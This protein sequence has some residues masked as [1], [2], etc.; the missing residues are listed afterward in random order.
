V[1][2]PVP[3]GGLADETSSVFFAGKVPPDDCDRWRQGACI[4]GLVYTRDDSRA[5]ASEQQRRRPPDTAAGSGDDGHLAG[6]SQVRHSI[7][8]ARQVNPAARPAAGHS[9]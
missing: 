9:I 3:A 1:E 4:L 6:Q 7:T 2:T 8:I 5:F